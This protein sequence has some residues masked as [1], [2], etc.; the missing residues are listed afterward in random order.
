MFFSGIKDVME[1]FRFRVNLNLK[2]LKSD[3]SQNTYNAW[4]STQ[5]ALPHGKTSYLGSP[6]AREPIRS[7][8]L[9]LTGTQGGVREKDD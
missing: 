4:F 5:G 9:S 1:T 2:F 8:C 7:W 3:M 6:S